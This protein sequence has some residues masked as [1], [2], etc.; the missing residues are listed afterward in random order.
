MTECN[1]N[2]RDDDRRNVPEEMPIGNSGD[3]SHDDLNQFRTIA[4]R[5]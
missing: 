3:E 4:K 5:R 2:N 1:N